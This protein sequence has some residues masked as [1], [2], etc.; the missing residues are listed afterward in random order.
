M[1]PSV[2]SIFIVDD[3]PI[4][5]FGLKR[6]IHKAVDCDRLTSFYNGQEALDAIVHAIKTNK[7]IPNLIFLDLN[8][9]V[10]DGWEFLKEF[11][12]LNLDKSIRINILTSSIDPNDYEKWL[13]FKNKSHHFIDYMSKPILRLT[14]KD[15]EYLDKAS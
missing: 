4:T 14:A 10:M 13:H 1:K 15:I 8:M 7:N 3:D 2:R 11:H 5:I 6:L 12:D 9:P